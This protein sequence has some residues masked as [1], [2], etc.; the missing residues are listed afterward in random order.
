MK[1]G[2]IITTF[3]RVDY[4]RQC[5]SSIS[6]ADL[7]QVATIMIVDDCSTDK[8]T[9]KLINDFELDGIELIKAFSKE[10]RSIKWSLL[11]GLDILFTTCDVVMNLDG[12]AIITKDAVSRL[13]K[14]R[15]QFPGHLI[16]GFNCSTK[17]KN[18]SIRHKILEQG[19]GFNKKYSV[20]GI[21]L[22]FDKSEYLQIV[23]PAL[24]KSLTQMLNWD[25]QTCI[26]SND[27][28]GKPIIVLEPSC[29]QHIAVGPGSSSMGHSTGGEPPDVADD[30]IYE[31][32]KDYGT[33]L[34]VSQRND[35]PGFAYDKAKLH[36]PSVTLIAVD[37]NIG[38]IIKAADISC[39]HIEFGAVKLLS[40]K[41]SDDPRAIKIRHLGSKKEYSQF[42]LKELAAYIE[43][44]YALLIQHD[45]YVLNFQAWRDTF[46][47]YDMVG[48]VWDFRQE[49][50]T[51]NGGF[52][53][54]SRR[55]M[56][57]IAAD[58]NIYLQ[59]DHIITNYAED[60]VLFY[61][62]REYLEKTHNI[63][64]AP[65]DVCNQFSM[66]AWGRED[67]RYKGSFGFHG[68]GIDFSKSN[69]DHT[70]Y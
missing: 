66:E 69:L 20:G 57:A 12:D 4:L 8:E 15:E 41:D 24:Q 30:F 19:V 59:N 28:Y 14:L 16:T 37:D 32:P 39:R 1:L 58:D 55:M 44:P 47:E 36:I 63:K 42:V 25:H 35:G 17:N 5:L 56:D 34:Y 61:I 2:L 7:S 51:A 50:R 45:G 54:R 64:I 13:L 33:R 21:Q 40:S 70:P 48:A 6:K 62:Y 46:L 31:T 43:T 67:K 11:F 68:Y 18:G 29:V 10:N 3:N 65:E 23:R 53:I 38:A 22:M 60:H 9:I 49:K 52:S 26:I 27:G